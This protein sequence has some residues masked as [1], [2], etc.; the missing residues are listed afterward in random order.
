MNLMGLYQYSYYCLP[1]TIAAVTILFPLILSI[2][3]WYLGPR[4]KV[5]TFLL[6]QSLLVMLS[7][8]LLIAAKTPELTLFW[9]KIMY[10]GIILYPASLFHINLSYAKRALS[11]YGALVYL[12][13]MF[14]LALLPTDLF[15]AGVEPTY[16]GWGKVVG[17][18]YSW[19][20]GYA[21]IFFVFY[22]VFILYQFLKE[23]SLRLKNEILCLVLATLPTVI[24]G[25]CIVIILTLFKITT[26][27]IM[28]HAVGV[29]WHSIALSSAMLSK[30][31]YDVYAHLPWFNFEKKQIQKDVAELVKTGAMPLDYEQII[32][33]L[34]RILCVDIAIH[35]TNGVYANQGCDPVFAD[36]SS[37]SLFNQPG[38]L[39]RHEIAPNRPEHEILSRH[40]CD[41]LA[42]LFCGGQFVGAVRL[43]MGLTDRL[44]SKYDLTL[45]YDLLAQLRLSLF[46]GNA[47]PMNPASV[48][49]H[50]L[51]D[52]VCSIQ[53]SGNVRVYLVDYDEE[54]TTKE[55]D[56]NRCRI[57]HLSPYAREELD[58]DGFEKI[59]DSI[60]HCPECGS[61]HIYTAVKR[62]CFLD[63]QKQQIV[64]VVQLAGT[65]EQGVHGCFDCLHQWRSTPEPSPP[66]VPKVININAYK[67]AKQ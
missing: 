20:Q 6:V 26:L 10:V 55:K 16:W 41:L 60:H 9:D 49:L 24:F 3:R 39:I 48:I 14:F 17:P 64:E 67:T 5:L 65:V 44:Y 40:H 15:I 32:E 51:G 66:E 58:P 12:P 19:F 25:C 7:E 50:Q 52:K 4:V 27:N 62:A 13:S 46:Y 11:R 45:I 2:K 57:K 43:G 42:S 59:L 28:A 22:C 37:N 36:F 54:S 18:G 23:P 47:I 30:R 61:T 1:S 33:T 56:G 21:G 31:F 34:N 29:L 38:V 53:K 8:T 35:T 63:H